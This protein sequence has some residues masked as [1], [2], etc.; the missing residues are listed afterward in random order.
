[1][2]E[3]E[4][5]EPLLVVAGNGLEEQEDDDLSLGKASDSDTLDSQ[6]DMP[7]PTPV[8]K[9][10]STHKRLVSLDIMRGITMS[11]CLSCLFLSIAHNR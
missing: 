5:Q 6:S 4:R 1:M 2:S 11:V 10:P 7:I 9:S 3:N 8:A